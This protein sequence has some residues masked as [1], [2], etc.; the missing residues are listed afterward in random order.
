MKKNIKLL[1]LG[2]LGIM[3]MSSCL[4]DDDHYVDFA[5]QPALA[6]FQLGEK[7]TAVFEAKPEPQKYNLMVN[8]AAVAPLNKAVTLTLEY[9]PDSLI[10][11][12]K[13]H[14]TTFAMLPEAAYSIPSLT[15]NIP[16]GERLVGLPITVNAGVIDLSKSYALPFRIKSATGVNVSGNFNTLIVAIAVKNKWDGVYTMTGTMEDRVN[17]LLK[18]MYPRE[19]SLI[20]TGGSSVALWD[21]VIGNYTH[22]IS[23]DGALSQYGTFSPNFTIDANN[24][25]TQVVN[26]YVNPANGR[27]A[28]L[29]VAGINK[30][31]PATKTFEV[32]Y[33]MT[34]GGDRT[35]FT[36]KYVYKKA[37]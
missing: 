31:D 28:R 18:G 21:N 12:N 27:G 13:V 16:A 32:S 1:T 26:Y 17:G 23:N 2:I 37:R 20:T 25:I 22:A 11:Y 19:I 29:N 36:E 14:K 6:E 9:A 35:F 3:S 34:Q 15:V 7:T 5:S 33:V 8:I 10:S 4:K 30:Y 24:A